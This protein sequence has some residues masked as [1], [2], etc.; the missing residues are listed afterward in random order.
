MRYME[1]TLV[2]NLNQPQVDIDPTSR[3][4]F[5]RFA[6]EAEVTETVLACRWPH[7]VVRLNKERAVVT[8]HADGISELNVFSALNEAGI[9]VPDE[10][11]LRQALRYRLAQVKVPETK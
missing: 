3:A 6:S 7:I 10:E 2:E 11:G 9:R 8:L 4:I 1:L 5:A